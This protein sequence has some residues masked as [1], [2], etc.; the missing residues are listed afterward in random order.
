M[1]V[2]LGGPEQRVTSLSDVLSRLRE[3]YLEHLRSGIVEA[4]REQSN[5]QVEVLL[6]IGQGRLPPP[7]SLYRIDFLA[8]TPDDPKLTDFNRDAYLDFEPLQFSVRD[9]RAVLHPLYWNSVEFRA[10]GAPSSWERLEEW[11]R[12]AIDIDEHEIAGIDGFSG[13]VHSV[14]Q[15]VLGDGKWTISV[16]FGSAEIDSFLGL[17]Q[18]MCDLGVR[19][20]AVGSFSMIDSSGLD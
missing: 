12:Q 8:G 15:P 13:V 7:Y 18:V 11:I 4:R 19:Q 6:E 14:T 9:L 20:L 2:R 3:H 5:G 17:V 16:D 1:A 10:V